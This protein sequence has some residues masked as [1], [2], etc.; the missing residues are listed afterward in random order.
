MPIAHCTSIQIPCIVLMCKNLQMIQAKVIIIVIGFI[1]LI[2]ITI[3]GIAYLPNRNPVDTGVSSDPPINIPNQTDNFFDIPR[4]GHIDANGN[5]LLDFNDFSSFL[6]VYGQ[7]CFSTTQ[8]IANVDLY[9]DRAFSDQNSV[10]I[11]LDYAGIVNFRPNSELNTIKGTN[12]SVPT[13]IEINALV[14]TEMLCFISTLQQGFFS[15]LQ[16]VGTLTIDTTNFANQEN[17][18][19]RTVIHSSV[20][21]S[22]EVANV[23]VNQDL[24]VS[25]DQTCGSRDT[26]NNGIID[27]VDLAYFSDYY[28][29]ECPR[30]E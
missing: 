5:G 26:D 2:G 12:C 25:L 20:T 18:I 13:G 9:I 29:G 16:Y 30:N 3:Y 6:A 23:R 10:E 17:L 21:E 11:V 22:S 27:L 19:A 8:K 24:I 4:C 1:V 28:G 7:E 14:T 15:E